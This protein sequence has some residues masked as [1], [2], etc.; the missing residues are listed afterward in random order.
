MK[1]FMKLIIKTT[2]KMHENPIQINSVEN[3]GLQKT[4]F[5]TVLA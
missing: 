3:V 2:Q 1:Y 4:T 5:R